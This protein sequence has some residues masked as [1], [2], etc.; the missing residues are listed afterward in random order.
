M[1]NFMP[2]SRQ[3]GNP[4]LCLLF[5]H[6]PSGQSVCQSGIVW[7]VMFSPPLVP[8]KTMGKLSEQVIHR[9]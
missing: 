1:E 7:D 8:I 2:C 6:L 9:R 3:K 4:L 5:F